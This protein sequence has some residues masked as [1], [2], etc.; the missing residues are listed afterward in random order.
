MKRILIL[1]FLLFNLLSIA[2]AQNRIDQAVER[3]STTGRCKF[4]SVVER[5]P[6]DN[7]VERVVKVLEIDE[8][9]ANRLRQ[10]FL[11]EAKQHTYKGFFE[12]G[13]ETTTFTIEQPTQNRIYML[14]CPHESN[15]IRNAKVTIIVKYKH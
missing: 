4:T 3:F 7:R 1:F 12:K 2:T 5:N 9:S 6:A 10:T 13:V 11:A 14:Q 15:Y 8:P